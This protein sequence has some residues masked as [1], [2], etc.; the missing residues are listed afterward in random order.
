MNHRV[1]IPINF[2]RRWRVGARYVFGRGE[3]FYGGEGST[4]SSQGADLTFDYRRTLRSRRQLTLGFAPGF[5]RHE[6]ENLTLGR[7]VDRRVTASIH[8]SVDV[9]RS[10]R[11]RGDYRRGL[12]QIPAIREPVFADDVQVLATGLLG[13][14]ADVSFSLQ[15]TEGEP[16]SARNG[17]TTLSGTSQGRLAL[18]RFLAMTVQYLYY[19]Y[20][21]GPEAVLPAE[22]GR[23]FDRHALRAGFDL[24]LPLH[25]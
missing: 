12:R 20:E 14:R 6:I 10:W 7:R 11:L 1:R 18:T 19:H 3:N 9:A 24:W 16:G 22:M 4:T 23:R 5:S 25:R 2:S 8:A 21:F 13:R 17:F 15:Y